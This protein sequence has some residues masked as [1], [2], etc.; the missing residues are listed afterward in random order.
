[1]IQRQKNLKFLRR[2]AKRFAGEDTSESEAGGAESES[3]EHVQPEE[4]H[5]QPKKDHV[6]PKVQPKEDHVQPTAPATVSKE[7]SGAATYD[8]V[9]PT[10]PATGSKEMSAAANPYWNVPIVLSDRIIRPPTRHVTPRPGYGPGLQC[11]SVRAGYGP[12]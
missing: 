2:M 11:K 7:M 10:A 6:Q 8:H 4:D 12:Y 9:Q 5:V 3:E 1:M